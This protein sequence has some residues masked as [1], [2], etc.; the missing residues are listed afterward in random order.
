MHGPI[1]VRH[2]TWHVAGYG[3]PSVKHIAAQRVL[4]G[5]L[6]LRGVPYRSPEVTA[7]TE[8]LNL[9]RVAFVRDDPDVEVR[10]FPERVALTA[11]LTDDR[12]ANV[13]MPHVLGGHA[14]ALLFDRIMDAH[15]AGRRTV[16]RMLDGL[17]VQGRELWIGVSAVPVQGG[18]A[19]TPS[20]QRILPR[21]K[22]IR[23]NVLHHRIE[24]AGH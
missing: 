21:T 9:R 23:A 17:R 12:L 24:T 20:A 13:L 1:C 11:A 15:R 5:A 22:A 3:M 8:L 10:S 6:A 7:A 16:E 18:C 2:R 4:N 14:V 19:L